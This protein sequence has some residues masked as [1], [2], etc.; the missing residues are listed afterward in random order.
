MN[1]TPSSVVTHNNRLSRLQVACSCDNKYD[2]I[3]AALLHAEETMHSLKSGE[4]TRI[5][6]HLQMLGRALESAR[7]QVSFIEADIR[8]LN[9]LIST[10]NAVAHRQMQSQVSPRPCIQC[11]KPTKDRFG[12][13]PRC[14]S[15]IAGGASDVKAVLENLLYGN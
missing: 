5:N 4:V 14:A 12:S 15:H 10:A 8:D 3:P 1:D 6:A 2:N 13:S 9:R 11:R 7:L